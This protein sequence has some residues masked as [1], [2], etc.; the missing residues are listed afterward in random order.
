MTLFERAADVKIT[1][2]GA[3]IV[4]QAEKGAARSRQ[5]KELA[6]AGRD[7]LSGPPALGVICHHRTFYLPRTSSRGCT[8]GAVDAAADPGKL[9]RP[10]GRRPSSVELDVIVIALPFEEPGIVTQAVYDEPFRVLD[11]RPATPGADAASPPSAR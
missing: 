9:H 4:A 11:A 3:R 1:D 7:P 6:T 10:A 2:I 8:G 5:I